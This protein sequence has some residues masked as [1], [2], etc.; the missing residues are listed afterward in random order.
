ARPWWRRL[1]LPHPGRPRLGLSRGL[2]GV[3][4][5]LVLAVVVTGTAVTGSSVVRVYRPE[6]PASGN[7]PLAVPLLPPPDRVTY[8]AADPAEVAR[9]SGRALAYLP[10]PPAGLDEIVE[11][12]LLPASREPDSGAVGLRIHALVRYR[13]EH[14][15]LIVVDEPSAA[16][17]R[18]HEIMLG[19]RTIR[20]ADGR[21]AWSEIR[22]N[23]RES[24]TVAFVVDRYVV[25]VASDL[26]LETVEQLAAQVVLAPAGSGAEP[27]SSTADDRDEPTPTAAATRAPGQ[28]QRAQPTPTSLSVPPG[29]AA[30]PADLAVTGA[31]SRGG[32][33]NRPQLTYQF[34]LGNR[35]D[36]WAS[37]VRVTIEPPAAL[38]SRARDTPPPHLFGAQG[39]GQLSGGGGD[40]TFDTKGLDPAVV[41]AA[42]A[43]GLTVRVTWTEA[44]QQQERTFVL[45]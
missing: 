32:R 20:L 4:A 37:D 13:G 40:I 28:A 5:L 16:L 26:P 10:Q 31:V 36:G 43:E 30:G 27:R 14:T 21:E 42:L 6:D 19:D 45:R 15:L 44:G 34:K 22:P 2:V 41:R 1:T 8:Q 33:G 18:Q 35:G 25:V 17:A 23:W 11:V 29:S 9:E 24:S 39:P 12:G 3:A 7:P 38:A